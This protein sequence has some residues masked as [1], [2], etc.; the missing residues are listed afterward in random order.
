MKKKK[1]MKKIYCVY[2]GEKHDIKDIKCKKCNK[3]LNPKENLFFD[4]IKDKIKSN[5]GDNII[6]TIKNLITSYLYGTIL[7]ATII[8]TVVSVVITNDDEHVLEVTKKPTLLIDN[9]NKCSIE[10]SK[11]LINVCSE[12]YTLDGKVCKKEEL[13]DATLNVVCPDGYYQSGDICISYENVGMLTR[14]ECIAP[15]DENAIGTHVEEGICFVEYCGGWTDGECSAG[16]SEPIDFTITS[17]CP[18][19]TTLINGVCKRLTNYNTYY[20][21][22]EG[23]LENDKCKIINEESSKLGCEEGYILN[24]EC[25]ICVLGE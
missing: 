4:Y 3:K 5:I 13:I 10:N 7:T 23:A 20:S 8:F 1:E 17:Y 6:E 2:C 12:G 15:P 16:S 18:S 19:D 14:E 25:N 11:E 22:N 24:E 9:L 21:C